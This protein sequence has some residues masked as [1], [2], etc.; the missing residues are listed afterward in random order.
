MF[1]SLV[2]CPI[3]HSSFIHDRKR[4]RDYWFVS[5]FIGDENWIDLKKIKKS[6]NNDII[7]ISHFLWFQQGRAEEEEFQE[8]SSVQWS[9]G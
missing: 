2:L 9:K 3:P 4:E 6:N 5:L 7:I 8:G 1:L